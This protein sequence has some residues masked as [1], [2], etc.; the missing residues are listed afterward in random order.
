MKHY[1]V[2]TEDIRTCPNQGCDYAGIVVVDPASNRIECNEFLECP[3]C[4][5]KWNDP[6]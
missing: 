2:N 6:L 5:F 1:T 3:K 4:G